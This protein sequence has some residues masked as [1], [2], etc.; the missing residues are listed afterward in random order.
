MKVG[1]AHFFYSYKYKLNKHAG[2][3]PKPGE[4]PDALINEISRLVE[5]ILHGE[6]MELV[7]VA[8][9]RESHG[10]VLRI[11]IDKPGGISIDD[12]TAVSHQVSDLLDVKNLIHYPHHLEVSSPGLNRPLKKEADFKRFIGEVIFV[13]TRSLIENRKTFRGKLAGFQDGTIVMDVDGTQF[14]IPCGIVEKAH[15]EFAFKKQQSR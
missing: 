12:C 8:Y 5:E 3:E 13:R 15:L 14:T 2:M 1:S 10:W 7:D 11:F 6:H 9:R 4:Y